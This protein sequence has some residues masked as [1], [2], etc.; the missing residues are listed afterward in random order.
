MSRDAIMTRMSIAEGVRFGMQQFE[1]TEYLFHFSPEATAAMYEAENA[2]IRLDESFSSST[3]LQSIR[4]PLLAVEAAS[5]TDWQQPNTERISVLQLLQDF[6]F[7]KRHPN[8]LTGVCTLDQHLTPQE[9]KERQALYYMLAMDWVSKNISAGCRITPDTIRYVHELCLAGRV[10]N[11]RCEGFRSGRTGTASENT[12]TPST[13]SQAVQEL[14]DFVGTDLHSPVGQ[15]SIFHFEFERIRP[16]DNLNDLTGLV[17]SYAILFRRDVVQNDFIVPFSWLG[18][19]DS[20]YRRS[21]LRPYLADKSS[22]AKHAAYHRNKWAIFNSKNTTFAVKVTNVFLQ[23]TVTLDKAWHASLPKVPAHSTIDRLL[24][25]MLGTPRFSVAEA[26]E[27]IGKSFSATNDALSRLEKHG[28]VSSH[29]LNNKERVFT[30]GQSA[31]LIEDLFHKLLEVKRSYG[32]TL[33]S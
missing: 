9:R 18:S 21:L 4:N 2:L 3:L 32:D 14:C 7:V 12:P 19:A 11:G 1:S 6:S 28:I 16:F 5:A 17:L 8:S 33:S 27:C 24:L 13:I 23:Q 31:Q 29:M 30:A 25:F 10:D 22:F 15:S 26:A 20:G